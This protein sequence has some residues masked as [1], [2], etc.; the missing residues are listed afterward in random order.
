MV[1]SSP[2][3]R[4]IDTADL[5]I[6]RRSSTQLRVLREEWREVSGLLDNAKRQSQSHLAATYNDWN[7]GSIPSEDQLWTED[8]ED[9]SF[10]AARAHRGLAWLWENVQGD[11]VAVAAHGGIFAH[12]TGGIHPWIVADPGLAARFHNC[13]LR[14]AV[15]TAETMA[16]AGDEEAFL[17]PAD[18]AGRAEKLAAWKAYAPG[19]SGGAPHVGVRFHLASIK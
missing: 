2:H 14:S 4:A 15:L 7:C 10:S 17:F 5:V 1:I 8:L 13:E 9:P 6:P 19:L 16:E 11:S 12:M 3:R 18:M